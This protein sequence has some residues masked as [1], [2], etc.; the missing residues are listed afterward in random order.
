M[1][2][3][4]KGWTALLS[5]ARWA[6]SRIPRG[7]WTGASGPTAPRAQLGQQFEFSG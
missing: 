3:Q 1:M 5:L 6:S 7:A 4:N 2:L